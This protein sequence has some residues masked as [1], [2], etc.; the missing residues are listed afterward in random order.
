MSLRKIFSNAFELIGTS[1]VVVLTIYWWAVL[2][3]ANL[4]LESTSSFL[5]HEHP[6]KTLDILY[7]EG[8]DAQ[9]T[10]SRLRSSYSF[11]HPGNVASGTMIPIIFL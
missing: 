4:N 8:R 10:S 6:G 1:Y 5:V 3:V 7:S 9:L 11:F 2:V